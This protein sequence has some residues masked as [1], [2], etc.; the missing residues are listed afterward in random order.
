MTLAPGQRIRLGERLCNDANLPGG[1]RL[2]SG[3][4][5]VVAVGGKR[6][7]GGNFTTSASSFSFDTP[8][9][10]IE[11]VA[12][13]AAMIHD[14]I[15]IQL[16]YPTKEFFKGQD[17]RNDPRLRAALR[18]TGKLAKA[19][20][21]YTL[22][23]ADSLLE[24]QTVKPGMTRADLLKVFEEEGGISTRIE[25]R[26]A[27]RDCPYIKV[28]VKFDLALTTAKDRAEHP[29]DKISQISEPFLQWS[30][31]D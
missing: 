24:I 28:N 17:P 3:I 30:I 15:R 4:P 21:E 22:W 1:K 2:V 8:V 18:N 5:F 12:F 10:V 7:Y 25:R 31:G 11:P 16:G 6:I 26:Y 29:D 9:I 19:P 20:P 14:R 27:Y 23:I 13:N